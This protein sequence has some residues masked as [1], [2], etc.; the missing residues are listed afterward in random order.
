VRLLGRFKKSAPLLCIDIGDQAA[1]ADFPQIDREKSNE[2]VTLL[3]PDQTQRFGYAAA[4]AVVGLIPRLKALHWFMCLPGVRQL[5]DRTY[6][7]I[8]PHRHQISRWLGLE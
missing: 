1:M 3:G 7:V 8:S 6:R 2:S 5:G 4:S